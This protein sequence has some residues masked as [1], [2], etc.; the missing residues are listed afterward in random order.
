MAEKIVHI[1]SCGVKYPLVFNINVMEEIQSE[2]GSVDKWG[3]LMDRDEPLMGA[4][5]FGFAAMI[6]EGIDIENELNGTNVKPLSLKKVGRI[7]SDIGTDVANEQ[8][9]SV[10]ND[11]LPNESDGD[12]KN[13]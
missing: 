5:K 9:M 2:Y 8:M 13:V 4:V 7:L 1:E 12:E 10:V 6:N 11:A 3:E